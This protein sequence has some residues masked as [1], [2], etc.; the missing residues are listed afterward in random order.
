MLQQVRDKLREMTNGRQCFT[1]IRNLIA[2]TNRALPG[3]QGAGTLGVHKTIALPA[4]HR[5]KSGRSM[6]TNYPPILGS[7]RDR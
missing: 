1:P 7:G 4:E 2:W 3:W 5:H 6:G